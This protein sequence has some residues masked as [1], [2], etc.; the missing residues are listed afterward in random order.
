MTHDTKFENDWE[1]DC[2]VSQLATFKIK[3]LKQYLGIYYLGKST[4]TKS[5]NSICTFLN[6]LM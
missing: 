4:K 5:V 1:S 3:C 6:P 2:F